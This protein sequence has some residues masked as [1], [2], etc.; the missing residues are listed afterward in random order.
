MYG[1]TFLLSLTAHGLGGIPQTMLGYYADTIRGL[2]GIE[3]SMKML[4][5]ISFGHP[6]KTSA[7]NR[8]RIGK[9]SIEENVIFHS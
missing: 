5:G 4:F 9:A 8:Y 2:L 7:A 3:P 1:Q 6:D